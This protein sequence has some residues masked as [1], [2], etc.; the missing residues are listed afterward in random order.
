MKY[1]PVENTTEEETVIAT[2]SHVIHRVLGQYLVI[3]GDLYFKMLGYGISIV[4]VLDRYEFDK[5][6]FNG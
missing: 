3:E 2:T 5:N 4:N 6:E 1:T